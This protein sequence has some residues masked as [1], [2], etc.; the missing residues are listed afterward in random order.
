MKRSESRPT[1]PSI[2][3]TNA[4]VSKVV[5]GGQTGV[6]RAALDVALEVGIPC[7]GWCPKGRRAEDGPIPD[8]YPLEETPSTFYPQRTK[9]NVRDADGTLVLTVGRPDGGTGLTLALAR[10]LKKLNRVVYLEKNP[11]IESIRAWIRKND[12]RVLNIAGPRENGDQKIYA[13]AKRFLRR[14]LS[15]EGPGP[16]NREKLP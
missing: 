12:L 3:L 8:R 11:A 4:I 9:W 6:D 14:L 1:T 2:S 7:G 5:S 15:S 13:K 10:R 16:R